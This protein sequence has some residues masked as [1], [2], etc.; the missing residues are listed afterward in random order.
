MNCEF[1][2]TPHFMLTLPFLPARMQIHCSRGIMQ[3]IY[4]RVRADSAAF[5]LHDQ[6]VV[7]Q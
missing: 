1:L 4:S 5:S 6:Q 3:R 7:G 2:S